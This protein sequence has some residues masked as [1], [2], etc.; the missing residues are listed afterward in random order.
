MVKE[1]IRAVRARIRPNIWLTF[2]IEPMGEIVSRIVCIRQ[3]VM[4]R[5]PDTD[6]ICEGIFR[7]RR[8]V[9]RVRS[10][11]RAPDNDTAAESFWSSQR[12]TRTLYYTTAARIRVRTADLPLCQ[13]RRQAL[14]MLANIRAARTPGRRGTGLRGWTLESGS[15]RFWWWNSWMKRAGVDAL[16]RHM[17]SRAEAGHL[18]MK[19]PS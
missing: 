14:K 1:A 5:E 13:H 12:Q 3:L 17:C 19:V 8:E 15:R 4:G 16:T 11:R 7:V 18:H 10:P 2:K 6:G 9:N